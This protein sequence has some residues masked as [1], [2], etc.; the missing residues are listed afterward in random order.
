M[1]AAGIQQIVVYGAFLT[2]TAIPLGLYLAQVFSGERTFLSPLLTPIERALYKLC[3]VKPE[4]EQHW[5]SYA[6]AL[7]VFNLVSLLALYA[8][9][10]LQGWLPFNPAG[11]A[12]MP[13]D[14][15]FNTA[16]SFTTNTNWQNYGG[17]S[18][19][20][21]FAQMAGLTVHNFTSAA[22][23]FA[24]A[25][26]VIRG[27]ARRT[28]KTVGNFYVDLIR[29]IVHVM[30]PICILYSLFLVWQ[31]VPQNLDAYSSAAGLDGSAQSIA[32][33]PVATQ[34]AIKLLGTNGGGFF[35]ANSAHPFE[36]PTP[37]TNFIEMWS[38]VVLSAALVFA[39]GK[40]VLDFRQG[41]ALYIAMAIMC[42]AGAFTAYWAESKPN[43]LYAPLGVDQAASEINPGGNMEGKEL[44]FGVANS[45]LFATV[46]TDTSCGAVNAMHDSFMP[47]G[48]MV[49][50]V[51]MMLSEVIF[52]GVG[53][54]LHGTIIFV[55]ITVFIAGL[56]VGR[57]PE[58][59]GKKMES[60]EIKLAVLVIMVFPL[61]VLGLGALSVALPAGLAAI[62]AAGPHGLTEAVYA[63]TSTTAN[64][65]SAFGGFSGNSL[66]QNSALATAMLI[67]RFI[68]IIPTLA[69]AGSVAAKK[70]VP[71]SAGTFPTHGSLFIVLL[72]AVI[73]VVGGLTFFPVLALGPL[74]EHLSLAAG[75]SF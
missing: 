51:N 40:M 17:E 75:A 38:L 72:I 11:F 14:L 43:P 8:I 13:A 33:G 67:G 10:R 35:N 69:I 59:L 16:V 64:N 4:V 24:V 66:Y 12:A 61:S 62:S 19:L 56:M 23:G 15:A 36:N 70:L 27:F 42:G 48:G 9:L 5:T 6:M 65:G 34:E 20:S 22:T 7:L 57:T 73:L 71:A 2:A 31:G 53:A 60:K 63:Y 29:S 58:Y 25:V 39:F 52:G 68:V 49:P 30:L 28:A 74:V 54:G 47:I 44:R 21:Y 46:T 50:L 32:Q 3:A 26:T 1:N 18:A 45:A 55:I 37:L 41:R